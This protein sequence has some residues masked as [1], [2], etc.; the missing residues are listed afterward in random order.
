MFHLDTIDRLRFKVFLLT[1][2]SYATY[3]GVRLVY[4]ITKSSLNNVDNGYEPFNNI[5]NGSYYL[6]LLDTV[7]L[8]SY[9]IGLFVSGHIA[10]RISI[11]IVLLYGMCISGISV[12]L[13]GMSSMFSIHNIVYFI[14]LN[15][16]SGL[17][18][19]TGWPSNVSI[20]SQY[21]NKN[22]RGTIFG[23]WNSHGSIGSIVF[24][25]LCNACII[26]LDW[27]YAF[28][29]PGLIMCTV[30]IIIYYYLP[31]NPKHELNIDDYS[32]FIQSM[33]TGSNIVHNNNINNVNNEKLLTNHNAS[34]DDLTNYNKEYNTTIEE[35]K[36]QPTNTIQSQQQEQQ[37]KHLTE[38]KAI[39]IWCALSIPGVITYSICLSLSK[40]IC[41]SFIMWLPYY[42]NIIGYSQST[43]N[44]LSTIYDI[45]G[46]VGGILT[47]YISDKIHA[48][49]ITCMMMLIITVP[50]LYLYM[51]VATYSELINSIVM[52]V[53]GITTIGPYT[54]VSSAVSADLGSHAILHGNNKA[55]ATVTGIIDGVGS[56]GGALSGV[57]CSYVGSH[58]GWNNVLYMLCIIAAC[59]ALCLVRVSYHEYKNNI[60]NSKLSYSI[61]QP[62]NKQLDNNNS[63][64]SP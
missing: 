27:T 12:V 25:L 52:F 13:F 1:F 44:N 42:L 22:N 36:V 38:H 60:Q 20:L 31:T 64:Q 6:G 23:I 28:I 41:Y 18:Q 37:K 29:V 58:Y 15:I 39:S 59:A 24:K 43:A 45:G 35:I 8:S 32:K 46:I 55:M 61:V 16:I 9:A 50:V 5:N 33:N 7:F 62:Y 10:D 54:L 40:L 56:I 57:L 49:G 51:I 2:I 21:F 26:Y 47:G 4:S 53:L 14:V 34:S 11:N 63:I 19:S 3:T 48:R 30:G 17:G